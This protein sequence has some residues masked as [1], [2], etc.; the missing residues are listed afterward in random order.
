VGV[1]LDQR[2]CAGCRIALAPGPLPGPPLD[3]IHRSLAATA[4][5]GPAIRLV[6][7]LKSGA[8]PA[9]AATMAELLAESLGPPAAD[10]VLVPVGSSPGR[11]LWRGLDPALELALALEPRLGLPVE[12]ILVRRDHRRQ[13]G[14]PRELRLADPPRF[15]TLARAPEQAL[16]VD[17]VITTGGTLRAC[18]AVLAGAGSRSVSALVFARTMRR[19]S[20]P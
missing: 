12:R 1:E 5:R 6:G 7:A 4:Y 15:R 14:R 3:G 20:A 8:T 16:L 17:D 9:A 10:A 18:A 2:L 13:R 11:L 19:C